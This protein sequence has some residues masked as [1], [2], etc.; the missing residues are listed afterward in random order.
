MNSVAQPTSYRSYFPHIGHNIVYLNHAATSPVVSPV[1]DAIDRFI[2]ASARCAIDGLQYETQVVAD[3]HSLAANLVNAESSERIALTM[4]TSDAINVIA[5]GLPWKSGDRIL[6][7]EVEF[8]A[9]VYPFKNLIR[10]GVEIDVI[11]CP[12][13]RVTLERITKYVT[14]ATK[15]LALSA[16]QY[17][18]GFRAHLRSIGEFCRNRGIWFVV[19]GIQAVGSVRVDVRNSFIDALAN[20]CQKWQLSPQGT[21]YVYIS[22]R[23]QDALSPAYHGWLAVENP[24]DFANWNQN[25][26]RDARRFEGGS[27]NL[28]GLTGMREALSLLNSVSNDGIE[29]AVLSLSGRLVRAAQESELVSVYSA[30]VESERAGIVTVAPKMEVNAQAVMKALQG[31]RIIVSLRRG[32]FRFSPHFYNTEEEVG[33]SFGVFTDILKREIK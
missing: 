16:V 3:C 2:D 14:P 26:A 11:P 7:A 4:N 29:S 22:E 25:P 31:E 18:S 5:S 23:L 13:G 19:D 20:G 6:L 10:H 15:L 17:L 27:H 8:P 32:M 21:G 12:D 9:N 33:T 30:D 1:R 28:I 24:V